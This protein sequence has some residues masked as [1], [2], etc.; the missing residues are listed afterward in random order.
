M[1]N[2][3]Y[4]SEE[5][6]RIEKIQE[7]LLQDARCH[8]KTIPGVN[9]VTACALIGQIGDINRFQSADKL[10]NYGGVAPLC[11][12]SGGKGKVVQNKNQGNRE[13]YAVLY[14]LA[15]QQIHVNAQKQARNPVLLAYYER[16]LSEGKTKIQGLLCIMRRLINIIYG[17]MKNQTEY[18]LP[19]VVVLEQGERGK[20]QKQR[21]S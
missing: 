18:I 1:R 20:E 14:L 13:L 15:I 5:L 19:E 16:K 6:K 9:T 21:I 2:I 11:F 12:S 7:T 4:I 3:R 8:L 17:M 10:A